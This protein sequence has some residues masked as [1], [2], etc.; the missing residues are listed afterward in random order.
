MIIQPKFA[1]YFGTSVLV[2]FKVKSF[3]GKVLAFH[4]V[5]I[6]TNGNSLLSLNK[7]QHL[8]DN[9]QKSTFTLCF[10]RES[11]HEESH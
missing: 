8:R 10:G 1:G 2:P 4:I 5:I 7:C 3:D 11:S 9:F 6:Q